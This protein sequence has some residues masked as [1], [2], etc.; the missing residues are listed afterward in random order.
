VTTHEGALPPSGSFA[1]PDSDHLML[2]AL[3]TDGDEWVA[4]VV[5]A[6]GEAVEGRMSL[7]WLPRAAQSTDILGENAVSLLMA[8]N[9]FSFHAN[10]FE[11]KTFRLKL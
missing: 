7:R 8:G 2:H 1:S 9:T 5:E 4:R 3:Y 11:I 6:Q 10:P